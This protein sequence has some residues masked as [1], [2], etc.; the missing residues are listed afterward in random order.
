MEP[1]HDCI[2]NPRNVYYSLTYLA[3][4]DTSLYILERDIIRQELKF[5]ELIIEKYGISGILLFYVL[6]SSD[7]ALEKL[8]IPKNVFHSNVQIKQIFNLINFD[9]LTHLDINIPTL[10]DE[11]TNNIIEII[12]KN[13]LI[14]IGIQPNTVTD[15]NNVNLIRHI[16]R[17]TTISSLNLY[18]KMFTTYESVVMIFRAL[19][20]R[21]CCLFNRMMVEI[22]LIT[23]TEPKKRFA[24]RNCLLWIMKKNL[25]IEMDIRI[26][27]ISSSSFLKHLFNNCLSVN[28]TLTKLN[29][30]ND[31]YDCINAFGADARPVSQESYHNTFE[32]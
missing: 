19:T 7:K 10:N 29:I 30:E 1:L 3:D 5:Y 22:S 20:I 14:H 25:V 13:K 21:R 9:V 23:D 31:G 11:M 16:S 12:N 15:L 18:H 28:H 27:T 17:K 8:M 6:I 4:D 26:K 2:K 24:S 32:V